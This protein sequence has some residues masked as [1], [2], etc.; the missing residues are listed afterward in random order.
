MPR[1]CPNCGQSVKGSA[2]F[3]KFCGTKMG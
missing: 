2:K 1:V 3:C